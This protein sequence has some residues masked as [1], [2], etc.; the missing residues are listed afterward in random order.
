MSPSRKWMLPSGL[1]VED[2]LYECF[3][4]AS[5]ECAVHSWVIDTRDSAVRDCLSDADWV[6]I[7]A[8]IP[9]LPDAD[10]KFVK[11]MIQYASVRA[12]CSLVGTWV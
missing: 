1:C 6:A 10:P 4:D 11:S 5:E 2:T 7:C 9:P 3:K 12:A 8:E